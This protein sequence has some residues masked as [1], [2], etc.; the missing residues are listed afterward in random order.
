MMV[1][2]PHMLVMIYKRDTG[3]VL[4]SNR[5]END[6]KFVECQYGVALTKVLAYN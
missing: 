4:I 2:I 5:V 3:N 1:K 6:P